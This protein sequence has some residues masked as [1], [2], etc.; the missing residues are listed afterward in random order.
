MS[1]TTLDQLRPG[2]LKILAMA[3]DHE[4]AE[5]LFRRCHPQTMADAIGLITDDHPE[6]ATHATFDAIAD[7]Y[8]DYQADQ[9]TIT[10]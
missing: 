6:H 7:G 3:G 5:E 9:L 10:Q 4:A 8:L 2:D 1:D